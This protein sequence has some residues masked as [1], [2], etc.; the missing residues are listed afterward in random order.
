MGSMFKL[1]YSIRL[2]DEKLEK[3]FIDEIR[4]RNG[5]LEIMVCRMDAAN[6]EV[7]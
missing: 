5:N 1:T 6:E 4:C 7:L 3:Q 2:R